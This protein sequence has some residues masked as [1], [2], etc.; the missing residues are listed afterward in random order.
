MKHIVWLASAAVLLASS[1]LAGESLSLPSFNSVKA[2]DGAD[3]IVRHGA[4]QSVV[5]AAGS[6]QY[7]KLEVRDGVLEIET[8]KD[9]SCPWHYH[10]EVDITMPQVSGLAADDGARIEAQGSFPAQ[11]QFAAKATDGGRVEARAIA[12]AEVNAVADDGGELSVEPR[13]SMK[14]KA[15]DGGVVRYWG[16]PTVKSLVAEDGGAVRQES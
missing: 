12:A 14:A 11:A 10:L 3:V 9:W 13:R 16:N 4:V 5:L 2:S 1:A 7:S 8:C 15:E 6:T